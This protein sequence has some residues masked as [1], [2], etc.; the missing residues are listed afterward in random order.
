MLVD[1][2]LDKL[3]SFRYERAEPAGF[4]AFWRDVLADQR[5][6]PLDVRTEPVGTV[7]TTLDVSDVTFAGY[8]ADPVRAWYIRPADS[9][10]ALPT[11]VEFIGYGGGRGQ[12]HESLLWASC[13][14]AHLVVDTRGQGAVWNV[15]DT[16]DPHGS[17]PSAPGFLTRGLSSPAE[18]YYTRVF[19]D[20]VRAIAVARELP[21]CD[22][23]RLLA[24]GG[25]QGGGIAL[26]AASL[27]GNL[28]GV[29]ARVPFL[30][31]IE[32]GAAITDRE[33]VRRADPL[34]RRT[35]RASHDGPGY[36]GPSRRGVPR[37]TLA[38]PRIHLRRPH[39]RRVPTL[40]RDGRGQRLCRSRRP[41]HLGVE[42][43]RRRQVP[44]TARDR[45][46]GRAALRSRGPVG[47]TPARPDVIAATKATRRVAGNRAIGR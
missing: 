14:Y 41:P 27:T 12:P 2:S 31:A 44:G 15:G 38:V 7:L 43:P 35:S 47:A 25:S 30:C 1:L 18:H 9:A 4:D 26:A 28:S 20:A 24:Y 37:T 36:L 23:D 33:P 6:H 32:R 34:A 21:G 11:V 40:D 17:G 22:P 45:R 46:M 13:G 10:A 5:K 3:R 19:V 42:R 29:C 39:G 8:G 16:P